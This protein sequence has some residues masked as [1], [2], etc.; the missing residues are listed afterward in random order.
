MLSLGTHSDM[1]KGLETDLFFYNMATLHSKKTGG[2]SPWA[3]YILHPCAKCLCKVLSCPEHSHTD[4]ND[5]GTSLLDVFIFVF[6]LDNYC[7]AK[8]VYRNGQCLSMRACVR[9]RVAVLS[10]MP[11][12][13]GWTDFKAVLPPSYCYGKVVISRK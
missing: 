2:Q 12:S 5:H 3:R 6:R 4:Q 9:A 11:N 8:A 10:G 1:K 13:Y 7:L